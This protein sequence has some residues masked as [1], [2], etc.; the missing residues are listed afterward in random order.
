MAKFKKLEVQFGGLALF[1]WFTS[2]VLSIFNLIA[3][4][5]NLQHP[6]ITVAGIIIAIIYFILRNFCIF[7]G[8]SALI[9]IFAFIVALFD[10]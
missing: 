4:V 9:A 1:A 5:H 10:N 2:I 7:A 6:A 8:L 3:L